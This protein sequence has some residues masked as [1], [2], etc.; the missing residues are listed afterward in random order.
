MQVNMND[1]Y[2]EF[3]VGVGSDGKNMIVTSDDCCDY[4]CITIKELEGGQIDLLRE[5]R[6]QLAVGT[7]T[8]CVAADVAHAKA[9][10][11]SWFSWKI[12]N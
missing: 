7:S 2:R 1:T 3:L 5:P 11:N 8:P 10:K 12:W 6:Q 4:K 9:S